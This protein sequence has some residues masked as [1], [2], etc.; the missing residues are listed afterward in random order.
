MLIRNLRSDGQGVGDGT[1]FLLRRAVERVGL[2]TS[3]IVGGCAAG[4]DF[5]EPEPPHVAQLSPTPL[6]G[7][8]PS[9]ADQQAY[10]QGLEIPQQWWEVF[11]CRPLN[12]I[13]ERAIAENADLAAARAAVRIA[14]ANTDAERGSAAPQVS[15]GFNAS[16]QKPST[17]Q[18]SASGTS[19]SPYSLHSGQLSVSYLPD[20][21]GLNRRRVETLAARTEA[22]HFELEATYLTLTSRVALAAIEEA[23]LRDEK[24]A[25]RANIAVGRE[26]LGNLEQQLDVKDVSRL[27]VATQQAALAEIEQMLPPIEKRLA[28]NRDLMTAL[29][30]H[31]A[32]E[33]LAETFEFSCLKVPRNLPLSLPS[34]IVRRRPDVRAAEANMHAA[35]ADIGVAVANRLPQFNLTANVG[36][37][38]SSISN[39]VHL[40]SPFAFWTMAGSAAQVLFDGFSAEQRQRA[41]EAGLDRAAALYRSAVIGAFQNVADVLQGLEADS[42]LLAATARGDKAAKLNL[43]LTR[44]M[45][46]LGQVNAQ[47]LLIAQQLYARATIATAR[48]KAA[49][50]SDAVLL[51]QALGGGW[52]MQSRWEAVV[53]ARVAP[54]RNPPL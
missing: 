53:N 47:Q 12:V 9:G 35:T 46:V 4:P 50:R 40:T 48:A 38:A 11:H 8:T 31:L 17:A 25:T 52:S 34:E 15:A 32:G 24:K 14:Q 54:T 39:L 49:I 5:R 27:D 7:K 10:V 18:A 43:D 26:F 29:T 22:Q 28:A 41:A 13:V 20:V 16:R 6:R 37:S 23:A 44:E 19:V 36:T 33:G 3:L 2:L 45:L 51:F 42:T 1:A 30:G 21:F